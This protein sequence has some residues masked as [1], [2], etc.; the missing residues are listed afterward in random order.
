[1]ETISGMLLGICMQA[2][3]SVFQLSIYAI[4]GDSILLLSLMPGIRAASA[5]LLRFDYFFKEI[6]REDEDHVRRFAPLMCCNRKDMDG[7]ERR[8]IFKEQYSTF[9]IVKAL[10]EMGLSSNVTV[11]I[12]TDDHSHTLVIGYPCLFRVY[13]FDMQWIVEPNRQ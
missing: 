8:M 4:H 10:G 2:Q 7:K 6:M 12:A 13:D 1:V 3:Y 5:T 11:G 9:T